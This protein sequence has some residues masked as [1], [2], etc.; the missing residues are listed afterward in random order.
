MNVKK[1]K[2]YKE[3]ELTLILLAVLESRQD[4][5]AFQAILKPEPALMINIR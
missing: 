1:A 2:L 5:T 3:F 4:L